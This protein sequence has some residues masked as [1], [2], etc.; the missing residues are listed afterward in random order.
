M[1]GNI[2]SDLA[3]AREPSESPE[4][5]RPR[6]R[7]PKATPIVYTS[8]RKLARVFQN[9]VTYHRAAPVTLS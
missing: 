6:W 4:S 7:T 9:P 1:N 5:D 3:D 2:F 8:R